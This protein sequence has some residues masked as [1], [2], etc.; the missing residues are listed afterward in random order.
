M[1][2]VWQQLELVHINFLHHRW[3]YLQEHRRDHQKCPCNASVFSE[4]LCLVKGNTERKWQE[5]DW[6]PLL[7]GALFAEWPYKAR[8]TVWLYAFPPGSGLSDA[9]P[10]LHW[11][12]SQLWPGRRTRAGGGNQNSHPRDWRGLRSYNKRQVCREAGLDWYPRH[13]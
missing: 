9:D 7:R 1:R 13:H 2:I 5:K 3:R 4:Q 8:A 12:P 10:Q 6:C 11:G